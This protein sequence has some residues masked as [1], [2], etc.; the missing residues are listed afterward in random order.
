MAFLH[1]RQC[2]WRMS[3]ALVGRM[4][5]PSLCGQPR[6]VRRGQIGPRRHLAA[7]RTVERQFAVGHRPH[8][9]EWAA[10]GTEIFVSRHRSPPNGWPWGR[11]RHGLRPHRTR[12]RGDERSYLSGDSGRSK[13]P[14]MCLIGPAALGMMSKSKISVGR[15]K[16]AQALGISTTPEMWPCTGAVPRIE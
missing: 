11:V 14:L 16:V 8:F 2:R 4:G 1:A 9:S 13:P 7:V 6:H 10:I 12:T 5:K 3:A 15:Y